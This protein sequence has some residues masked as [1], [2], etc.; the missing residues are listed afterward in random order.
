MV[1]ESSEHQILPVLPLKDMV[2]FPNSIMPLFVVRPKSL[3]A[4]D[5]AIEGGKLIF[6]ATQKASDHENPGAQ[7]LNRIGC[8]AEVLQ[9]LRLPDNSAKVLV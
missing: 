6:L 2:V 8:V 3:A 9:V 5:A 7:D 4:L 1:V